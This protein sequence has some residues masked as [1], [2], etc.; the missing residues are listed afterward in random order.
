MTAIISVLTLVVMVAAIIDLITRDDSQIKHL[1]KIA[2]IIIVILL[3]LIGSALWFGIGRVYPERAGRGSFGDPRR[4]T[5]PQPAAPSTASPGLSATELEIARLDEEI[6][7]AERLDHIRR[8]E[9]EVRQRRESGAGG[10]DDGLS[11]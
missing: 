6:A 8:L 7:E 4:W 3:P 10:A 5:T 1:P 11:P 2:W 9:R